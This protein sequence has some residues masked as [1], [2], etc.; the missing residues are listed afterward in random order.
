[1]AKVIRAKDWS[2]T[3]LGPIDSWPQSLRTVL[4]L[5]QASNAPISLAWGAA[6]TQ[7]YNDGYWPLCGVKHPASMGQDFR[8]CWASAW[9]EIGP[10]YAAAW[11]GRSAYLEAVRTFIDRN[12]FLE[13][14]C[15]T[16]SFSPVT[17]ESG[18]VGGVFHPVTEV[19]GQMLSERRSRTLRDLAS[20]AGK[21]RTSADAISLSV[22]VLLE[23]QLDLPF[24]LLYAIEGDV[25][26]LV[27]Q[28]GLAQAILPAV[29]ETGPHGDPLWSI[30]EV[31]R[32]GEAR[33]ISL[34]ARLAGLKIG[35]YPEQPQTALVLPIV[36]P[37]RDLPAAVLVAGASS[38]L[39]MNEAYRGFFDLAAATVA[40]NLAGARAYEEAR[41]RAEALAQ[42]DR[43]KTAFF[44]N[45]SHEFRTPLTLILGTTEAA[46]A[47]PDAVLAGEFLETVH[48]NSLRLLK[49]VNTLL[50]FSR[51]EAGRSQAKPQPTD[52]AGLT[53]DLA[54]SFRSLVE[55]A[56]LTLTVDCPALS[57]PVY[58][59][60]EMYEK[61]VLNLI[62]N[63]FKFTITG[64][65]RVSLDLH[66]GRA[67]LMVSDTGVGIPE[68]EMPRL[69]DRF[70]RVEG[71]KGRTYE[72]SGIGLALVDELAKLHGGAV[73]ATSRLGEGSHFSVFFALGSAHLPAEH[74]EEASVLASTALGAAPFVAEASHWLADQPSAIEDRDD[75][76]AGAA[77]RHSGHILLVDDNADMR[78]YVGRL[79]TERG[80]EVEAVGEGDAA[81]RSARARPPDLVL[82]DVMMPG[83]DGFG[84]LKALKEDESTRAV[85]VILLS[86]RAGEDQAMR[87]LQKGAD[88]YLVKPFSAKHLA[89]LIAAR[90]DIARAR[91]EAVRARAWLHAQFMQAPVAVCILAGP[92]LVFALANPLFL[93]MSGRKDILGKPLRAVFPEWS[94]DVPPFHMLQQAF[95]SG[96][97]FSGEEYCVML[98]RKGTGVPEEAY[99]KFNGQPVRDASGAVAD[100][101]FVAVDVTLQVVARQR[102][103]S[104]V[105]DLK[106]ADERK[107]EFLATLAHELRNPMAAISM[108]LSMI[109]GEEPDAT[110]A[111]RYQ[112]IARRQMQ[113][114]V[115][116]VD[117]LLD[118]ARISRGA[119]Q[120]REEELDLRTVLTHALAV[121][122]P[123]I[124]ER[125][126]ALSVTV[127][128]GAFAMAADATRLEQVLV[129]LLNN[130]AKY[131]KPGG[132]IAVTLAREVAD[133]RATAVL[134]VRDNGRGIPRQM[135]DKVFDVFVQVDPAID[136][137]TGGLGL[138]LTLVKRLTEMHGGTVRALS[139]GP[140]KGSEFVVRLPL[141]SGVTHRAAVDRREPPP[142][143]EPAKRRV[144]VVED[145]TDV[146]DI[147]KEYLEHL[148]H[149]VTVASTGLEGLSLLREH[150]PDIAFIDAGL[151]G[152]DG[153]ELARRARAEPGG[154]QFFLVAL[155]G[156]G[157]A[158]GK[159]KAVSA[160]FDLQL[161]KPVDVRELSR[162]VSGPRPE[163]GQEPIA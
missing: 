15:F 31:A 75:A 85:P 57:Q 87:G 63:A 77:R 80:W 144:L 60:R 88:D 36:L 141:A 93:E 120:L 113:N 102:V 19:T 79:L 51:I 151:P 121:S 134:G 58:V 125:G 139:E 28:A 136:R 7:I 68:A 138:G 137:S 126:H 73:S 39:P 4:S 162:V 11:S 6:H 122:R 160:G 108:A 14:T 96:E 40:I 149:E 47:L 34:G 72:G 150:R 41:G 101:I 89:S 155:T 94:P 124:E 23:A 143:S 154:D 59:D 35:P 70:H 159:A 161:T 55:K 142:A 81:L 1:M 82:A 152:I 66:E 45:V 133:G 67:R 44:S 8:E 157:G 56:G 140:G 65:I 9:P 49:L 147:L 135:L 37:G 24:A 116:L 92:D 22:Q 50:D 112:E 128:S 95:Q 158:E 61:I 13:E 111:A 52:L 123:A 130:A 5:T 83:L 38:R 17:D 104:L 153:Y 69:F 103:E 97:P 10:P 86:A 48:R 129:N 32:T 18:R 21:A 91:A 115:R 106:R 131:T 29:I 53:A 42:L 12:G 99:L 127:A 114:L 46:L 156:Y 119:V 20:R 146:R 3:P 2:R 145:T 27:G 105:Q 26:R 107:D 132:A 98:D 64:G 90:V 109:A 25:A 100:I 148:G 110:K 16:F 78:K 76:V 74:S 30:G 62:S 84:L 43:A 118:V 163:P 117:D 54:S 71:A 33:Q